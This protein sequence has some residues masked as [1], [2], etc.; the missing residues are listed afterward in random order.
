MSLKKKLI[1]VK[2]GYRART[3]MSQTPVKTKLKRGFGLLTL[4]TRRLIVIIMS[5]M[6]LFPRPRSGHEV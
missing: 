3:G 5:V 2:F 1:P 6:S 4:E